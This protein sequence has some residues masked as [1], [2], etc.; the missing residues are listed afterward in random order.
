MKLSIIIPYYNAVSTIEKLLVS[1]LSECDDPEI[2]VIDD[3]SDKGV[4]EFKDIKEK[5][6]DKVRFLVNDSG[7]KGAGAARN[8]GLKHFTGDLLM[9]ADADDCFEKGWYSAV[10][11]HMDGAYDIVY[12]RPG[13]YNPVTQE[14]GTRHKQ[15]SEYVDHFLKDPES[16]EAQLYLRYFFVV[17]WCKLIKASVVRDNEILFDEVM[18]S[19]DV[20]FSV[21]T[22]MHAK[23]V[24]ADDRRIYVVTEGSESLTKNISEEAWKTRNEVLCRRNLYLRERLSSKDYAF[25]YKRMR[26]YERLKEAKERKCGSKVLREYRRLYRKYRVPLLRSTLHYYKCQVGICMRKNNIRKTKG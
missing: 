7:V 19:N 5:Y 14:A 17:P 12:F 1:I 6:R 8:V 15:L 13:S 11:D 21:K 22:G 3:N 26:A 16:H 18:H 24:C 20:M 9:F 2:L 4:E 25:F 10:K 23:S